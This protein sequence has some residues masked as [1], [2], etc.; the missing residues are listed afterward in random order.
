MAM[1]AYVCVKYPDAKL[2]IILLPWIVFSA[3]SGIK[4]I[5]SLDVLG[6]LRGWAYFD[7]AA[8]LGGSL[9]GL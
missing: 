8:H 1:V 3:A 2:S 4:I 6:I 7:H 9:C 5:M